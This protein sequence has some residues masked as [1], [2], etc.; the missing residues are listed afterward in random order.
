M[1]KNGRYLVGK[2]LFINGEG[3]EQISTKVGRLVL[4]GIDNISP[5]VIHIVKTSL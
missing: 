1:I 3:V 5:A 4:Y 2:Y